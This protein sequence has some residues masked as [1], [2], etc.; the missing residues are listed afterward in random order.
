MIIRNFLVR[1]MLP[2]GRYT[3]EVAKRLLLARTAL[4]HLSFQLLILSERNGEHRRFRDRAR[5]QDRVHDLVERRAL[6]DRPSHMRLEAMLAVERRGS[7]HRH[8][9]GGLPVQGLGLL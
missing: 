6:G 1:V 9:L 5:Y 4:L 2:P 3:A 8:Q 7:A